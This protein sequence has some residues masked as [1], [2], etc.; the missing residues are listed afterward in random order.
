MSIAF[1]KYLVGPVSCLGGS[2][3][4]LTELELDVTLIF[5]GRNGAKPKK[6]KWNVWFYQNINWHNISKNKYIKTNIIPSVLVRT[7]I[8][9]VGLLNSETFCTF[10]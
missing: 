1:T 4:I 7:S 9:F 2:H 3:D 10:V 5:P 6:K 8:E